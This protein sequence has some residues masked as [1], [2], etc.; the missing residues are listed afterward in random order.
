MSQFEH[1]QEQL[2][3]G[4][5]YETVA[6]KF[7]PIFEKIAAGALAREQQRILPFEQI[8]WLKQAGFG[9]VRVPVRYGGEGLSLPQLFQLL[10]ELAKADSNIVQALRGHF[11]FVEDRLIAHK[12]QSQ[13][14]WFQRFVA[15]DLVGNAWTEVGNV[16]IGD[17]ITRVTQN[18]VGQRIVSGE[19]YYSTGSIFSDWIDLF[20]F[21]EVSQQNVIAAISRHAQGVEI[22]DDWDGFG[23]K[24]TGSGTITIDQV[25]VPISHILPFDQRFKYQTA[26]Y[27]VIHLATLSGIAYAAVET[28]SQEVRDRKRIFSH[29]NADLVRH[30]PQV[31]QVI[32]KASAQAYASEAITQRTAEA[33][34]RAYLSH[35][36]EDG[37][38]EHQ[39]NIDAELESAQG[40]VVIAEL[41]LGLTSQ[42]F[43]AL[44]ASA[45][46]TSKQLDRF[47]RNARTVSSHNPLIYKEKAI[48]DWE[49]NRAELPFVWQIGASPQAKSA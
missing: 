2:S 31:L 17:V 5:D 22:K 6:T 11:A 9:A 29:G 30:D 26:F 38:K 36:A 41:V 16:Q 13:Q 27:Q 1:I 32:G 4:A 24:T 33:L 34:Q 12:T 46:S 45:A 48:G 10:T 3:L 42:L 14:I 18:S 25:E 35:F 19:K 39:A 47:W 28:F 40:Q 44:S 21:D 43:N 15:G 8:E 23:Q 7:R 20:A 37:E 49:V